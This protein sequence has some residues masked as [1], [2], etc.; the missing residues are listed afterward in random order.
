M[1]Y[2]SDDL[3]GAYTAVRFPEGRAEM[4]EPIQEEELS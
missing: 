1:K 4:A 3:Q 2:A